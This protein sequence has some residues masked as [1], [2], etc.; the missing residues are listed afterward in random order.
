MEQHAS[1]QPPPLLGMAAMT[2]AAEAHAA[3]LALFPLHQ[4]ITHTANHYSVATPDLSAIALLDSM[5]SASTPI[6]LASSSSS[7]LPLPMQHKVSCGSAAGATTVP[8]D[9][10]SDHQQAQRR[11]RSVDGKHRRCQV[12]MVQFAFMYCKA[13]R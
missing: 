7:E 11:K 13:A 5:V 1:E 8:S 10:L 2:A 3:S 6:S 4:P 12:S 9:V